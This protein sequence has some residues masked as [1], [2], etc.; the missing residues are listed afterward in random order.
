ML[1][2]LLVLVSCTNLLKILKTDSNYI[3]SY[4]TKSSGMVN[5][6]LMWMSKTKSKWLNL[7]TK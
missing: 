7:I 6:K 1:V 2:L 4:K 3:S 5:L